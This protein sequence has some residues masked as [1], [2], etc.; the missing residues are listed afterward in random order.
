M[1]NGAVGGSGGESTFFEVFLN[2]HLFPVLIDEALAVTDEEGHDGEDEDGHCV[3][4]E[5]EGENCT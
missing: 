1:N 3:G 4:E 2:K 5:D